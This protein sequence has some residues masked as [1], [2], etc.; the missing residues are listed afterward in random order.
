M[1]G[2]VKTYLQEK[3]YGFI[4]GDD[5]KDY[6]FHT[7]NIQHRSDVDRIGEGV[8]L[9]FE[10]K[11]TPKGYS[12]VKVA[13]LDPDTA[14]KYAVPQEVF[15]SKSSAVKGWETLEAAG[16][17]VCGSTRESPDAAKRMM[18][19]HA[20]LLGAN[21][22]V[23]AEYFKTTGSEPGTG[24][25]THYYTIHNF[26]GRLAN[27]GRRSLSGVTKDELLGIDSRAE[28]MKA[29]L[30]ED[31][32]ASHEKYVSVWVVMLCIAVIAG[33][34]AWQG[35]GEVRLAGMA[36][37][38]ASLVLTLLFNGWTDYAWWLEKRDQ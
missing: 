29:G 18:L 13:L 38:A 35:T 27:I 36:V 4:K 32:K 9:S 2:I 34:I 24:K 8:A 30:I 14:I 26:R 6:F 12:A 10:Q 28:Q 20:G 23:D 11:A 1:T 22:V 17:D 21:A 25:G 15:F 31:T 5:G 7:K 37:A 33:L 3:Q 19:R 16:W